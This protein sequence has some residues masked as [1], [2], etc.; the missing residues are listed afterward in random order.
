[1]QWGVFAFKAACNSPIKQFCSIVD[2]LFTALVAAKNAMCSE[3][4]HYRSSKGMV[5]G[6]LAYPVRLAVVRS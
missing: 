5:Y 4:K 2:T 1:M 3:R 6:R